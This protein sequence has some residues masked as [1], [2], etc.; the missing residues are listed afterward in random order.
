MGLYLLN[1]FSLF[2]LTIIFV[3]FIYEFLKLK[4]AW[5]AVFLIFLVFFLAD[6]IILLLDIYNQKM[7]TNSLSYNSINEV[8]V[9]VSGAIFGLIFPLFTDLF[10]KRVLK[11]GK[12]ITLLITSIIYALSYFILRSQRVESILLD[13]VNIAM[14]VSFIVIIVYFAISIIRGLKYIFNES[15]EKRFIIFYIVYMLIFIINLVAI[16]LPEKVSTTI[17]IYAEPISS[18]IIG[19][20]LSI[21]IFTSKYNYIKSKQNIDINDVFKNEY[22][23]SKREVEITNLICNGKNSKTIADEL[24]I[25][26]K[27]VNAHLHNIYKKCR[28]SGKHDLMQLIRRFTLED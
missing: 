19:L 20:S 11:K 23:L 6:N 28:I 4:T 25:S 1:I 13:I 7:T 2:L 10:S 26:I 9:G 24:F 5:R 8:L 21:T 14:V 17:D 3:Q 16:F 22:R 18:I 27:T 15:T 12:Y